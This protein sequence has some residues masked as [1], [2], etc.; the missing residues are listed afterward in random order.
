MGPSVNHATG[1]F[2]F[3]LYHLRTMYE[4]LL[5]LLVHSWVRW[6]P[7]LAYPMVGILFGGCCEQLR[8]SLFSLSGLR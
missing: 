3:L 4:P 8:S 5:L 1:L 6:I 2:A 7:G